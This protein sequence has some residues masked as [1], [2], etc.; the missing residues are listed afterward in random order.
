MFDFHIIAP[1][2]KKIAIS[3]KGSCNIHHK[4][5]V[6]SNAE[7][8]KANFEIGSDLIVTLNS[9]S[10]S[11]G[12]EDLAKKLAYRKNLWRYK[13]KYQDWRINKESRGRCECIFAIEFL[14]RSRT[15]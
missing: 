8:S 12:I 3:I 13:K 7:Y 10:D 9:G 15:S 11:G 4:V 6:K 2:T 14:H 5:K 1:D